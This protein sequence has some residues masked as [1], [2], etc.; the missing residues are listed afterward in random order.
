MASADRPSRHGRRDFKRWIEA[1]HKISLSIVCRG[2][3]LESKQVVKCRA[4]VWNV[5][6]RETRIR[7][8]LYPEKEREHLL[9]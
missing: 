5:V 6:V 9:S 7:A 1:R 3:L 4:V 8:T 2:R